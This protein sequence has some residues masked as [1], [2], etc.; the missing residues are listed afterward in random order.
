MPADKPWGLVSLDWSVARSIWQKN[1]NAKGTVEATSIEGCRQL[2]AVSPNTRC[3]MCV[4]QGRGR[5][6]VCVPLPLLQLFSRFTHCTLDDITIFHTCV[7]PK[8]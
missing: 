8:T 3:F 7:L 2:K 1:G 5:A 4:S 6:L